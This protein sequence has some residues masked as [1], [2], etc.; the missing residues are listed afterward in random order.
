IGIAVTAMTFV[1]G[2]GKVEKIHRFEQR[3]LGRAPFTFVD[4]FESRTAD[5]QPAGTCDYCGNGIAWCCVIR[6]SDGR[7][8][9]VG[10][11]CVKQTGDEGLTRKI[12]EAKREQ[13]RAAQ[14]SQI[15][16]ELA[17]QRERNGGKTDSEILY[18]ER[19]AE[20][21]AKVEADSKASEW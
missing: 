9:Q 3:G 11:E 20:R 13:K 6:S 5:G 16:A 18:E 8:F 2:Y 7:R 4:L 1:G 17:L 21:K 10:N 14:M 15:Q 19:E 12:D